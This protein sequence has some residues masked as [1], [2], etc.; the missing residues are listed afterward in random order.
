MDPSPHSEIT[1]DAA[2]GQIVDT[3][4]KAREGE[5]ASQRNATAQEI[6]HTTADR[7]FT[8]RSIN[9]HSCAAC[10]IE[11]PPLTASFLDPHSPS[12]NTTT[13]SMEVNTLHIHTL[14]FNSTE[15]C[16]L[17][18]DINSDA[19]E[20]HIIDMAQHGNSALQP[21]TT[22]QENTQ[23]A[24]GPILTQVEAESISQQP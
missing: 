3:L 1:L 16:L 12:S 18:S 21:S 2:E 14:D 17:P 4:D 13:D 15:E 20:G 11:A 19:V 6:A 8:A 22:A 9:N 5:L 23:P 24:E 7:P 10:S